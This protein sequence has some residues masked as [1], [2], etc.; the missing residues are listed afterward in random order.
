M[1]GVGKRLIMTIFE[2]L[3]LG[4]VQGLAEF[5]P[6]SSSGH[7]AILQHFLGINGENALLFTVML[8]AGS[9]IAVFAAY[10]KDICELIMELG[11][12]IGDIF[13]GKGLRAKCNQ[14]RQLGLMLIIGSIPAAITGI[15][16]DEVVEKLFTS[17]LAVGVC[18]IITG[19]VLFIAEKVNSGRKD[20]SR[21][22]F[23]NA[24]VVGLFQA[25]AL[26]P[27]ISRSGATIVGGLFQGFTRELAV[28][29]AFLL[30]IPAV[31]GAVI[32]Q[33]PDALEAGVTGEL[34]LPSVVGIVVAA[35]SGFLAIKLMIKVVTKSKLFVFSIYTWIAGAVV[36]ILC[37]LG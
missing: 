27:G 2:A 7:L 8:H 36:V 5:L 23:L 12:L 30:S 26:A 21:A 18:L 16:F 13:T 37:I 14:T 33:I 34:L 4:L 20:L 17:V 3:I 22:G 24:F 32:L 25:V 19:T 29:F 31:L 9:L 1:G 11:R 15:L 10:W 6:I 28:R 35:V